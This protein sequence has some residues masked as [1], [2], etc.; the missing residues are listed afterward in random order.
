[1]DYNR[2][3]RE[4]IDNAITREPLIG[5]VE[6][7]HIIPKCVGGT[8]DK[9]NLVDLTAR[10][11]FIA[12]LLLTKLYDDANI[13]YAYNMMYI[14]SDNQ[15]RYLPISLWY[16]HRRKLFS[17]NH[18]MKNPEIA[19]KTS[20]GRKKYLEET[21]YEERNTSCLY[22]GNKLVGKYYCSDECENASK[23]DRGFTECIICNKLHCK[24]YCCSP[25]C[26]NIYIKIEGNEY[27]KTLSDSRSKYI[28]ENYEKIRL[29]AKK[30]AENTDQIA[31]GK[32]ISESKKGKG[33]GI[34]K[35]VVEIYD[36]EDKLVHTCKEYFSDF[37]D[38]LGLPTRKLKESSKD[39][40]IRKGE[41]AGY[42]I[43]RIKRKEYESRATG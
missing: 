16:E 24:E 32:R 22:C 31:K 35:N 3:Y 15:E 36:I 10:E 26:F 12:H 13:V 7:H 43:I 42:Y 9:C 18:H 4:L 19:K 14:K 33:N 6:T 37:C 30:S 38:R 34:Y 25:E 39:N 21:P 28:S 5:Y 1:M 29:A 20:V 41:Y 17:E 23:I 2:I 11:H 8:D 27:S 40:R